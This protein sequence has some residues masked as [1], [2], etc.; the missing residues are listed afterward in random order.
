[1]INIWAVIVS[2]IAAMV[3]GSIWWGPLFGKMWIKEMG[4]ENMSAEH[5]AAMKKGMTW[6]YVQQFILSFIQAWVL[7]DLLNKAAV[8]GAGAA[9]GLAVL[10]WLGFQAP[11]QY[12]NKI[13]GGKKM[14]FVVAT[15]ASSLV[16]MLVMAWILA[17]W[18]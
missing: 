10:L 2:A 11:I 18:K 8:W 14:H 6:M 13:W 12:G 17:A 16:T 1:M 3:I 9:T 4:M 15:L 5:K 7:A